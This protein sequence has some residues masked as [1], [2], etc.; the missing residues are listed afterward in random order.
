MQ[1][2]AHNNLTDMD[3]VNQTRRTREPYGWLEDLGVTN[4]PV[5]NNWTRGSA[6]LSSTRDEACA[7]SSCIS[8]SLPSSCRKRSCSEQPR[9]QCSAY[10]LCR[11]PMPLSTVDCLPL[12][13]TLQVGAEGSRSDGGSSGGVCVPRH[14]S[15]PRNPA[16]CTVPEVCGTPRDLHVSSEKRDEEIWRRTSPA[17]NL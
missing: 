5:S 8:R 2:S 17:S 13:G 4:L 16:L 6:P 10:L 15:Q 1:S 7:P 9:P 12:S 14:L 3:H 11:T